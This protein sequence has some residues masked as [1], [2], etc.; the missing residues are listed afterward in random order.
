M[1]YPKLII[2]YEEDNIDEEEPLYCTVCHKIVESYQHC[3][4][5]GDE[6]CDIC[7]V[8]DEG[9]VFCYECWLEREAELMQEEDE[10]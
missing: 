4:A 2:I 8:D 5:C 10:W 3:D 7:G 9:I 6:I 1:N